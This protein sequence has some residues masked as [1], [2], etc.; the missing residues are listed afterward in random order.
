[1]NRPFDWSKTYKPLVGNIQRGLG[2]KNTSGSMKESFSKAFSQMEAMEAT[3]ELLNK[4]MPVMQNILLQRM[5]EKRPIRV[6]R[7]LRYTTEAMAGQ[8]EEEDDGFYAIKKSQSFNAKFQSVT[9]TIA[10]GTVLTFLTLEKS[11]N[12]MW[13]RT[14]RGE[15]IGIYVDEQK[16]LLTQ[17][18]IYD[19]VTSNWEE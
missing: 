19:L 1:L 8:T 18:D 5:V 16:A 2:S 13:F 10:P 14:D 11:M 12:Q 4:A 7:P 6:V 3:Q 15:E 17:T 9:R